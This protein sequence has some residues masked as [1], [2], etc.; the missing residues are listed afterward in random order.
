MSKRLATCLAACLA[1]L[2]AAFPAAAVEVP[3][4]DARVRVLRD[5]QGVPHV[6]AA[7]RHDLFF[8]QGWLH[9]QDRLF[10]MDLSRR[11]ASGTLAEVVGPAALASDVQLRT[12]GL[13]RA[14]EASLPLLS[15]QARADLAAYADGVNARVAS[16]PLPPEY[17]LLELTGFEPWTPTDSVAIAKLVA[18]GLSF[19]LDVEL[20]VNLLTYQQAGQALGFDGV[21][22]FFEDLFRSAPFDDA[23][24]VPDALV[25]MGALPARPPLAAAASASPERLADIRTALAATRPELLELAGSFL[26]RARRVPLLASALVPGERVEGSNEW[27]VSGLHT[28]SGNPL[29]ANDPHLALDTPATFYQIHLRAPREGINVIGSGFAGAPY[30]ILGQNQNVAWGAT[31]NPL[32]VTDVFQER[33]VQDAA[34]PSGLSIVHE[35]ANEPILPLPQIFRFNPLDGTPDNLATAPAGGDVGGVFIPPVVLVVPRRNNG[36]IVEL[37]LEVGIGLSIAYTGFSG[38]REIDTFRLFNEA[39][40]LPDFVAALQRFDVGSQNWAYADTGGNIAYFS[41]A[42]AP[43]REDLEARTVAGLPPWLIRNGTGGNEWVPLSTPQP[44]QSVPFEVLPFDE[45]PQIVNPPTG[46]FVN[47]NND[48]AGTTLDNDP[49]NQLRPTG[50]IY[51]LSP[52]YAAGFRAGRITQLLEAAIAAGPVDADDMAAIQADVVLLDSQLFRPLLLGAFAA[53]SAPGAPA[54]LAALAGDPR[55]AEAIGRL[56]GWDGSTPTGIPEGFDASDTAGVR[57]PPSPEEVAASIAATIYSTFRGR[58]IENT[59]DATLDPLGLPVP[60]SRAA[61]TA[62]RHLVDTFPQRQGV[63]ASGLDFLA[64]VT[65]DG[66]TGLDRAWFVLLLSL[67][68]ALDAL[69]GP[70]FAAAFGAS[71]DQDDYRWGRLHRV[72]FDHPL[73]PP[74]SIPPAFGAFPP[75]LGEELPGIPTDGGFGVVDASNHSARAGGSNEFMFGS[76]PVRR[77]VGEL[78][79]RLDVDARTSL[80]GGESGVPGSPFYANILPLWLTNETYPVRQTFEALE[81]QVVSRT[82]FTPAN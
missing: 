80:P 46:Y 54:E 61:M 78:R 63:G 15:P 4:L 27:A 53:A 77:Y 50:G 36:P 31:T 3:G 7:T 10:Q 41:S 70:E 67:Q 59:I 48:P 66:L 14:A 71:A 56:A 49:L 60:G 21:A 33:I 73:G 1:A 28:A 16:H 12:L 6:F 5:V 76:G 37:D 42:E 62:L 23:S 81:G 13:R 51:Y 20:T 82:I 18:F 55:V 30:V 22:L 29:M 47:A 79:G 24:T 57:Q 43:L 38:T 69:A 25:E 17:G 9:A 52:G 64:A 19:D 75:P 26:E 65:P 72:V 35:G 74:F 44:F 32:D 45:M 39:Q 34:S 8:M 11:Q 2:L 68:D 40:N 58:L